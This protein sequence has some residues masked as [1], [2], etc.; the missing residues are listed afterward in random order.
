MASP[1]QTDKSRT[2]FYADTHGRLQDLETHAKLTNK[3]LTSV[4]N[5]LDEYGKDIKQ[6][7]AII[8]KSE[9]RQPFDFFRTL[10]AA[11]DIFIMLATLASLSVW[12]ILTLTAVNDQVMEL[13]IAH[14]A[15]KLDALRAQ[16]PANWS[17]VPKSSAPARD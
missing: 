12:L 14:Q 5:I 2:E 4:R 11:R 8:T 10:S 3:E 6:L 13:K 16:L 9:S 7:V 15:E 17:V 1:S